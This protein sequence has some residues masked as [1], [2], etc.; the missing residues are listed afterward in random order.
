MKIVYISSNS[1]FLPFGANKLKPSRQGGPKSKDSTFRID[2]RGKVQLSAERRRVPIPPS[3][4]P[5]LFLL[6]LTGIYK[7]PPFSVLF[8]G[9]FRD[10]DNIMST[11][12]FELAAQISSP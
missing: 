7:N 12:T 3:P 6:H 4:P 9:F 8:G 11:Y 2:S 1:F 10:R 5:L